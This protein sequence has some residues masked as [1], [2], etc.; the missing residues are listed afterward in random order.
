MSENATLEGSDGIRRVAELESE[1][2]R[3]GRELD[4]RKLEASVNESQMARVMQYLAGLY[5]L[6]PGLLLV[7]DRNRRIARANPEAEFLL[8]YSADQLKEL[9]LETVLPGCDALLRPFAE[10]RR[11]HSTREEVVFVNALNEQIAVLL[12]IGGQYDDE[13]ALSSVLLVGLDLRERKRLEIELRHA[14]KLESLGQLAAGVAHEINTPMQFI[15]DNL[16]FIESSA[17]DLVALVEGRRSTTDIDVEFLKRRLPR[18]VE[19]AREGVGRVSRIVGAMR[20]F[21][22]PGV[23]AEPVEINELVENALTVSM[24]AFK[25]IADLELH[26]GEVPTVPAVRGDLGQV[27]LNLITNSAHAMEARFGDSGQRGLLRVSTRYLADRGL[28]E[29]SIADNGCGIPAEIAH[30]VF[31]PFFTTKPVGSGTGQGLSISH[32]LIVDKHGGE[33]LFEPNPP[34]GTR[35]NVRL[36][37]VHTSSGESA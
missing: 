17:S 24:N 37:L 35:F 28:V 16:H 32:N 27:L 6:I 26:L 23:V 5:D 14:Q 18:A 33:L 36:P 29:I 31:D 1:L 3:L 22:H 7:V 8:G 4:A 30:R 12:S 21:A 19:R 9:A 25:Y 2:A 13:G 10:D 34:Q 15:S 11:R 20:L